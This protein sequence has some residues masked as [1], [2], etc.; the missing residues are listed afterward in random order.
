MN[1]VHLFLKIMELPEQSSKKCII[2]HLS[3]CRAFFNLKKEDQIQT[4][5]FNKFTAV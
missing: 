5:Y 4:Q 3:L 2:V 1:T